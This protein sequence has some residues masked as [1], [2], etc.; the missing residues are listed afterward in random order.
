[1]QITT[2]SNWFF[3]MFERKLHLS[4]TIYQFNKLNFSL[5]NPFPLS[6]KNNNNKLNLRKTLFITFGLGNFW[7]RFMNVFVEIKLEHTF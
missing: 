6:I 5:C 3:Q 1:L 2:A 7:R 4:S